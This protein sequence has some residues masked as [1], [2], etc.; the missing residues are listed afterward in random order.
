V[1]LGRRQLQRWIQLLLY[2]VGD[3]A[4]QNSPLLQLA[5][6]R[7]RLMELLAKAQRPGS[8]DYH[9]RAFMVG[10]LSLLDALLGLPMTEILSQLSLNSERCIAQQGRNAGAVTRLGK[11]AGGGKL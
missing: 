8:G 9:E 2:T 10:I 7:G 6:S 4:S 3:A 5:A 1:V 11:R